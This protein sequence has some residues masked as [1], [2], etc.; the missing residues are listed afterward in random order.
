MKEVLEKK[1]QKS[2]TPLAIWEAFVNNCKMNLH[3]VLCMSPIGEKLR[4][5][6]RNFPSLV[7]C[8]SLIWILPW[9]ES[10]LSAVATS[11]LKENHSLQLEDEKK[12]A[13]ANICVELH[14]SVNEASKRFKAELGRYYYVTPISYMQLLSNL[15]R[16]IIQKQKEMLSAI[17]K[18]ENGVKKIG[19][20]HV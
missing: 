13:I 4:V 19:R 9:S 10:A 14:S 6:L 16:L 12:Q 2:L 8:T 11:Y 1:G 3:I 15:E 20:A 7:S 5:R 18:Y 17:A